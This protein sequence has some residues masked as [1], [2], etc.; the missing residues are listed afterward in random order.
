ME[1]IAFRNV[2]FKW[3]M[4][5]PIYEQLY[6]NEKEKVHNLVKNEIIHFILGTKNLVIRNDCITYLEKMFDG[7]YIELVDEILKNNCEKIFL[8]NSL[9]KFSLNKEMLKF[10]DIDYIYSFRQRKNAFNYLTNFQSKNC[11][12]LN[13]NIIQ[14]LN[15]QK[16]LLE[17]VYSSFYNE[18]YLNDLIEF[19]N[20]IYLNKEKSPLLKTLFYF[21]ISKILSFAYKLYSLQKFNENKRNKIIEKL[22]L[23]QEKEFLKNISEIKDENTDDLKNKKNEFARKIKT[24]I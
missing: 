18:K 17:S 3:L 2:D 12:L 22:N 8:T 7:N 19:Y 9:I 5:D 13:I 1:K 20:L 14:P 4:K 21:N 11:N 23:I 15:I 6:Q 24:K 16:K 10:F